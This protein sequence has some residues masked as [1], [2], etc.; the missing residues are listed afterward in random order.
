MSK[1]LT[2][3]YSL[4][5]TKLPKAFDGYTV[6]QISD[7]HNQDYQG[8]LEK[9][10][11]EEK[12]DIIVITGDIIH[13]EDG[14]KSALDFIKAALKLAPVYYVNGNHEKVLTCYPKF[15]D[16]IA[17]M[18]VRILNNEV[19]ILEKN[20]ESALLIGMD[21]P[22]F[23]TIPNSVEEIIVSQSQRKFDRDNRREDKSFSKSKS[24]VSREE[25]SMKGKA[26]KQEFKL[27]LFELCAPYKDEF[28]IVLSHR[29]E[30]MQF[31]FDVGADVTFTG[32]A[33]GGQVR[34]PFIGAVYAPNQGIF[35]KLTQGVHFAG[36][37]YMVISRGLGKSNFMPR[38][39][40]NP[41]IIVAKLKCKN[42][43]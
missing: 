9:R 18:G 1:L 36:E 37:Q 10:V 34:L 11:A 29:P 28:K 22:T 27:K 30:I 20:G 14:V 26:K 2:T 12:P 25:K 43:E 6:V 15:A 13:I 38:F 7:L 16:I 42:A 21:D 17:G 5:F 33:H 4:E 32:H 35:P 3:V 40:C 8:M 23:F 24:R 19:E 31:Y 39:R 41:E